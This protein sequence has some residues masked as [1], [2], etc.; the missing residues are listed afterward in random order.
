M[1]ELDEE[2]DESHHGKPDGCGHSNTL[3]LC[4]GEKH[5]ATFSLNFP[6]KLVY[7]SC[8][9]WCSVSR[10]S[11]SLWQIPLSALPPVA[12]GP[13]PHN[14]RPLN[15]GPTRFFGGRYLENRV[16]DVIVKAARLEKMAAGSAA[17]LERLRAV[18]RSSKYVSEPLTA[19]IIP[20]DDAHQ[21][22]YLL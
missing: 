21:V 8:Q 17:V 9:A 14:S 19:Y 20:T 22:S 15:K 4:V 7:P 5:S 16:Y 18:M 6:S 3:E 13:W 10:A 11:S 2:A 12:T 1:D